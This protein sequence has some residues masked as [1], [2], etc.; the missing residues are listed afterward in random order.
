M[1]SSLRRTIQLGTAYNTLRG[2]GTGKRKKPDPP[3]EKDRVLA[4]VKVLA[5]PDVPVLC[6]AR[7]HYWTDFPILTQVA[8]QG[9]ESL[10]KQHLAKEIV[11]I[12]EADQLQL[13]ADATAQHLL[14]LSWLLLII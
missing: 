3:K 11:T 1:N 7:K 4:A 14:T 6:V 9:D 12:S 13:E 10:V 8:M 2:K 5:N